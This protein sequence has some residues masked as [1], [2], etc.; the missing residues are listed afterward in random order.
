MRFAI[1][2]VDAGLLTGGVANGNIVC[3][4]TIPGLASYRGAAAGCVPLNP[5]GAGASSAAAR[6]Y[7]TDTAMQD[8]ELTQHV[9]A[10][11]LRGDLLE[12]WAGPLSFATGI[13]YRKDEVSSVID[14][15]SAANDFTPARVAA[16]SAARPTWMSPR[17]SSNWHCRLHG[18]RRS[19]IERN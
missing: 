5:F 10:L 17:A 6:D 7:V 13:E 15:I 3:R 14:A 1:D 18:S 8:T 12:L 11:T 19:R 16:S 9:L 2:S 4:A